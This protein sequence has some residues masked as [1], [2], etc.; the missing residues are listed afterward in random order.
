MPLR[1]I[2]INVPRDGSPQQQSLRKKATVEALA[3][4]LFS[5]RGRGSIVDAVSALIERHAPVDI[6]VSA[7]TGGAR[8]K[9][10]FLEM[11]LDG[12]EELDLGDQAPSIASSES[13]VRPLMAAIRKLHANL[14]HPH[15][16]R[17][18]R[19]IR[20]SGGSEAAVA[21]ALNYRCETCNRLKATAGAGS[22]H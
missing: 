7:A 17:L 13:E 10:P 1:E 16:R 20:L 12:E 19:A 8:A 5:P 22:F 21:A 2:S 6:L 3:T 18:A 14:G 9:G 11:D 15:P 4:S